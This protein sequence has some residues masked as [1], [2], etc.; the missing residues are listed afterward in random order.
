MGIAATAHKPPGT[1]L[2]PTNKSAT[3]MIATAI[4]LA[5]VSLVVCWVGSR[6]VIDGIVSYEGREAAKRWSVAFVHLIGGKQGIA[7]GK[8]LSSEKLE[9]FEAAIQDGQIFRYKV[10]DAKGVIIAASRP[11]DLGQTNTKSYFNDIV[12]KGGK[13]SKIEREEKFG[14]VTTVSEA[15]APFM[16]GGRFSGAIETYVDMSA[17]AKQL[18]RLGHMGFAA[19]ATLLALVIGVLCISILLT[20]RKRRETEE[21]LTRNVHQHRRLLDEAP[22][23]MVIHN[24]V[25]VLYANTAAAVLHGA[26]SPNDL[27]GIDPATLIPG[28]KND[29]VREHRLQAL[30]EGKV[31]RTESVGRRRLDGSVIETDTIGIP[32]EWNGES[33]ILIQSRDMSERRTQ[34]RQIVE[35]EAQAQRAQAQLSAFMDHSP[36]GMYLKDRD[37]K[38]TMVNRAYEKFYG[39][40]VNELV[41]SPVGKWLPKQIADDVDTLDLEIL[42]C[43][44]MLDMEAEVENAEGELRTLILNKFPIYAAN[45]DIVGIGGVNTDVT[46][47]RGQEAEV[48]KTQA[49][50][51]AYIDHIPMMVMLLDRDSNILMVNSQYEK[52]FG[53]DAEDVIGHTSEIRYSDKQL[54][55]VLEENR[56]V[57]ETLEATERVLPLRNAAGE[58]RQLHKIK[59][60]IV[61]GGNVP[62]TVGVVLT[63]I[64]EQKRHEHELEA[65]RDDAEAANRA[66]SAFLANM[67]HEI[68]TPMNGVFGMADLLARS[69]L[70]PDQQRYLNTIRGS[71]EALLGVINNVLDVSRIEAGEF[72]LDTSTFNL[73]DLIAEATELFAET[74]SLKN[75]FIAHKISAN[76]PQWVQGDSVR[77]RQVFINLIG[78]GIK[79]TKDGAVVVH[80]IRIGGS[81]DDALIRFEVTDTGIGIEREKVVSLFDPFQQADGSI[82]R[83]FGGTGL[84]LSIADHIVKLMGGRIDVDS[85]PGQGS[86]FQFSINMTIDNSKPS[87][88]DDVVGNIEN[89][90]LLIVDDNA[91]NREILTDFARDWRTDF[92][93]TASAPA[94]QAA[95]R[96]AMQAGRP[97]DVALIDIVMPHMDGIAL[98]QW[99][100]AQDFGAKTKLIGLTSFNWDGDSTVSREAGFSKFATKPVRRS[101]LARLIEEVL[102]DPADRT[103]EPDDLKEFA[104]EL[105]YTATYNANV[106][107]AEDNPVNLELAQEYLTRLGCTVTVAHNGQQAV[108][109]FSDAQFDLILMDVQMPELDG[110]EATR[111]IRDIEAR[112]GARRIPIIAATAHAFQEDREKCIIAGMDDFLSKPFTG[113]DIIPI[114]D[115]WLEP[116]AV[117]A[118]EA[119]RETSSGKRGPGKTKDSAELLDTATIEQLRSLDA[120]GE[121]RIFGKVA[122]I[123]LE[124][125]PDQLKQLKKHAADGDFTGITLIAHSLK[126]SA[127]NVSALSL[128]ALFRELEI[129]A[130][131]EEHET[132]MRKMDEIIALYDDVSTALRIATADPAPK[133]KTA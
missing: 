5:A 76:V 68:R 127:A 53:I 80:A 4:V 15:Y 130:G 84:G 12:R 94:A 45:G 128:S 113:Q 3:S 96:E 28:D 120:P 31:M 41:G 11:E 36:S 89:K 70:T 99:I 6:S 103:A 59:F 85:Q 106:L 98:A 90:R 7:A 66:K 79:F 132:C 39:L 112:N 114:L 16:Q 62:V 14:D 75:V 107:L 44:E 34:Q 119:S 23:S 47:V 74:A 83:K 82:T 54:A 29:V 48:R 17:R 118:D 64:T 77:L 88:D 71:G 22:D 50:L 131:N 21:E 25:R 116:A 93:V 27:I 101:E 122:G 20:L 61:T 26:T 100:A 42:R 102:A 110:I 56:R 72:R 37:L 38:V 58:E 51:S 126:T 18:Y 40:D 8:E 67:S 104:A 73:H 117:T 81:D 69:S 9:I 133:K 125:T 1:Q 108:D 55:H 19:L 109:R 111:R 86:G 57:C 49:R 95:M 63:D 91:I 46:E 35:R 78:N 105:P 129:A 121:D 115:R 33:C 2:K 30:R 32:I 10:F 65:A 24:M 124:N 60:P 123:F 52:F 87:S 97:F 92:V 43:G 13:Y